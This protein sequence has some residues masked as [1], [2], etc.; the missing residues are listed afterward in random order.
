MIIFPEKVTL[1]SKD[2]CEESKV[3][4]SEATEFI[5]EEVATKAEP[6]SAPSGVDA[7][8]LLDEMWLVSECYGVLRDVIGLCVSTS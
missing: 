3:T 2:E 5:A 4:K 6:E 7:E 1:I 8:D